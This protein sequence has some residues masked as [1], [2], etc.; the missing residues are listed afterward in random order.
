[1]VKSNTR[2][3]LSLVNSVLKT[4]AKCLHY[5]SDSTILE[6]QHAIG[7]VNTMNL[8][9]SNCD[10]NNNTKGIRG[11]SNKDKEKK[12]KV[13]ENTWIHLRKGLDKFRMGHKTDPQDYVKT[14]L[15]TSNLFLCTTLQSHL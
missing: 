8:R 11:Y 10:E 12:K 2:I 1:M 9:C 13:E 15:I 7:V 5:G 14:F 6:D 4:E 3:D